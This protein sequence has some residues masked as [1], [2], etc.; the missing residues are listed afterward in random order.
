MHEAN[1]EILK[2]NEVININE[3]DEGEL[4]KN[5]QQNANKQQQNVQGQ[6]QNLQNQEHQE[7]VQNNIAAVNRNMPPQLHDAEK[8]APA[9]ILL[10]PESARKLITDVSMWKKTNTETAEDVKKAAENLIKATDDETAAECLGQLV[11]AAI[12]YLDDHVDN[13]HIWFGNGR[14]RMAQMRV[15]I[16]DCYAFSAEAPKEYKDKINENINEYAEEENLTEDRINLFI[17]DGVAL[18]GTRTKE[19]EA[20]DIKAVPVK[21]LN[22]EEEQKVM[23]RM[24]KEIS[25]AKDLPV[26][27]KEALLKRLALEQNARFSEINKEKIGEGR[28]ATVDKKRFKAV[29]S[30]LSDM[31]FSKIMIKTREELVSN[32]GA[33]MI[34]INKYKSLFDEFDAGMIFEHQIT[35][36]KLMQVM[37]N[38]EI[39]EQ[40]EGYIKLSLQLF[41]NK[42]YMKKETDDSPE[43]RE[44]LDLTQKISKHQLALSGSLDDVKKHAE[45]KV[46]A[47]KTEDIKAINE[48]YGVLTGYPLKTKSKHSDFLYLQE[49]GL[50]DRLKIDNPEKAE[51]YDK[52]SEEARENCYVNYYSDYLWKNNDFRFFDRRKKVPEDELGER[53]MEQQQNAARHRIMKKAVAFAKVKS[54]EFETRLNEAIEENDY[55]KLSS[56]IDEA[57]AVDVEKVGDD[58]M[59]Q[60][61]IHLSILSMLEA[62]QK[63]INY[64]KENG[65]LIGLSPE[66]AAKLVVSC[67]LTEYIRDNY[68]LEIEI[69]SE[70]VINSAKKDFDIQGTK[71]MVQEYNRMARNIGDDEYKKVKKITAPTLSYLSV[72]TFKRA[73]KKDRTYKEIAEDKTCQAYDELIKTE[74]KKEKKLSAMPDIEGAYNEF[75]F[76]KHKEARLK[77]LDYF[78]RIC[79]EYAEYT[80]KD[81]TA[82]PIAMY[83][84]YTIKYIED[85]KD[86]LL[87][88]DYV[89]GAKEAFRSLET[90][91]TALLQNRNAHYCKDTKNFIFEEQFSVE[92]EAVRTAYEKHIGKLKK[93]IEYIKNKEECKEILNELQNNLD[94]R[95]QEQELVN[96]M[97][98]DDYYYLVSVMQIYNWESV[99]RNAKNRETVDLLHEHKDKLVEEYEKIREKDGVPKKYAREEENDKFDEYFKNR[100]KSFMVA[101]DIDLML[102]SVKKMLELPEK[103]LSKKLMENDNNWAKLVGMDS[104]DSFFEEMFRNL[105]GSV[106]ITDVTELK[107]THSFVVLSYDHMM[108]IGAEDSVLIVDFAEQL[109][110]DREFQNIIGVK[111]E[112]KDILDGFHREMDEILVRAVEMNMV[113]E[114][115]PSKLKLKQP[116]M[117]KYQEEIAEKIENDYDRRVKM[118]YAQADAD[119]RRKTLGLYKKIFAFMI[120]NDIK[121]NI[122]KGDGYRDYRKFTDKL[123]TLT[124]YNNTFEKNVEGQTLM[125]N[126]SLEELKGDFKLKEGEDPAAFAELVKKHN[127]YVSK[128]TL[129]IDL[130]KRKPIAQGQLEE[131]RDKLKENGIPQMT[132]RMSYYAYQ[133]LAAKLKSQILSKIE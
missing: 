74:T 36:K 49:L 68:R 20:G 15:I 106:D 34:F 126:N 71:D 108:G 111:E 103:E 75:E 123:L 96:G 107:K 29:I 35:E 45:D 84:P 37:K 121:F 55:E 3:Y 77:Q 125:I 47:Q 131:E 112:H 31:D 6:Q 76:Q 1:Q 80:K 21:E 115:V 118:I 109:V 43:Y 129:L 105:T 53:W 30:E 54:E 104:P 59:S 60:P 27:E 9:K 99:I 19:V 70:M 78:L 62:L 102:P 79:K 113:M 11:K 116:G 82:T 83:L 8:K 18:F 23:L 127:E 101:H 87:G 51:L 52:K 120:E 61:A 130:L 128:G 46:K 63:N 69:C 66:K 13:Y 28:I 85:K 56:L 10:L 26:A 93:Q 94:K 91:F 98:Y 4:E 44:Y 38:R 42:Y 39:L 14:K 95:L 12:A 88:K 86:E 110:G 2:Q 64:I 73:T 90:E 24:N 72:G 132:A 17:R 100:A 25:A 89:D 81:K 92:K 41:A 122:P 22:S 65:N 33:S 114:C 7:I 50:I 97:N 40:Y 117:T 5:K 67:N 133:D 57:L 124:D 16:K 32:A 48:A 58:F 119:V